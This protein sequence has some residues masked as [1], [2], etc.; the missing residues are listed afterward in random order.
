M[1]G[2]D[3]TIRY[4]ILIALGAIATALIVFVVYNMVETQMI[5]ALEQ[6]LD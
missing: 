2:I 6:S 5:S 4:M 1:K 3:E